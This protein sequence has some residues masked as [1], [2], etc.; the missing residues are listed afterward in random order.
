MLYNQILY[1]G[2][3]NQETLSFK[4]FSS[5][6]ISAVA[7]SDIQIFNLDKSFASNIFSIDPLLGAVIALFAIILLIGVVVSV[8]YRVPGAFSVL[9]TI[10]NI[11]LTLVVCISVGYTISL[12]ILTAL[13]VGIMMNFLCFSN[14][15]EKIK[16]FTYLNDLLLLGFK[17]GMKSS[18]FH[19]IDIHAIAI[20]SCIGF[21]YFGVL[22]FQAFGVALI[23]YAGFSL[24]TTLAL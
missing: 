20:L 8:L 4:P 2:V 16:K 24:V 10:L 5:V 6:D 3:T 18:F 1:F 7:E 17:K 12:G 11:A 14:I 15:S 19:T 21:V 23:V 13:F 9:F 22:N